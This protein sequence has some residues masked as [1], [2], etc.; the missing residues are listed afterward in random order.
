MPKRIACADMKEITGQSIVGAAIKP[1]YSLASRPL[2]TS[3]PGVHRS[4]TH[5]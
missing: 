5:N 1:E 4:M 3:C 2:D